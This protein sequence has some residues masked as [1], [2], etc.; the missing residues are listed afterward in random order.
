MMCLVAGGVN[1]S[2]VDDFFPGRVGKA[3]PRQTEQTHCNQN[4]P[5]RL[6]HG[7]L[8]RRSCNYFSNTFSIC[9]TFLWILPATFS[10][11]PSSARVGLLMTCPAFS[12]ALPLIS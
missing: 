6:V 9:P 7:S 12:L 5:Q 4:D 11:W 10:S 2:D 1:W 3:S 8:L